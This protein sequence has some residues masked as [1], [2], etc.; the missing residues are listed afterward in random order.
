MLL[1]SCNFFFRLHFTK[2]LWDDREN[3]LLFKFDNERS[4]SK[5]NPNTTTYELRRVDFA[6]LSVGQTVITDVGMASSY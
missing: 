1:N 3:I 4:N 6:I 2:S 5:F